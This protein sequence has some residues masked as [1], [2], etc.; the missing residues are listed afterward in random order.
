[1]RKGKEK[2]AVVEEL[3][4]CERE[5]RESEREVCR[6]AVAAAAGGGRRGRRDRGGASASRG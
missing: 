5:R 3:D 1:M 6:A 2:H 4:V